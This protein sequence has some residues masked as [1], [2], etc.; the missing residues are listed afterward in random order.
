[1]SALN[2][3]FGDNDPLGLAN[4]I[5]TNWSEGSP[6]LEVPTGNDPVIDPNAGTPASTPTPD[7][8]VPDAPQTNVNPLESIL[9]PQRTRTSVSK[10]VGARAGT[11]DITGLPDLIANLSFQRLWE[12]YNPG[13]F[14]DSANFGLDFYNSGATRHQG[15]GMGHLWGYVDPTWLQGYDPGK[16][17]TTITDVITPMIRAQ[18]GGPPVE[19]PV[20][21]TVDAEDPVRWPR[22]PW[23]KR[24][25]LE[26]VYPNAPGDRY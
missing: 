14:A 15:E 1:M 6:F 12:S 20:T 3:L 4:L 13:K 25:L 22:L 8:P 5:Y 18:R 19:A 11:Q 17:I 7:A 16:M 9:A 24:D 23:Y 26:N 10:L 21:P 2:D